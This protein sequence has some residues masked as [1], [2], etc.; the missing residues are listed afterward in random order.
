M[1]HAMYELAVKQADGNDRSIAERRERARHRQAVA[2]LFNIAVRDDF[3]VLTDE[4]KTEF[5]VQSWEENGVK[6]RGFSLQDGRYLIIK[7]YG[8]FQSEYERIDKYY[9]HIES[10]DSPYYRHRASFNIIEQLDGKG[11]VKLKGG[12]KSKKNGMPPDYLDERAKEEERIKYNIAVCFVKAELAEI[13]DKV[14]AGFPNAPEQA[15]RYYLSHYEHLKNHQIGDWYAREFPD[16]PPPSR[17]NISKVLRAA[18]G[19]A[20]DHGLDR[21]AASP[22]LRAW[23]EKSLTDNTFYTLPD[24]TDPLCFLD[25]AE[26]LKLTTY[27]REGVTKSGRVTVNGQ[28]RYIVEGDNSVIKK[29]IQY[30]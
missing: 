12:G 4:E 3:D 18:I 23:Y 13:K 25:E 24:G 6:K 17:Q 30:E 28:E 11:Y 27:R 21:F 9:K 22:E 19:Y 1:W 5:D 2:R 8:D 26:R 20:I 14:F 16:K 29:E 10:F 15:L 7:T